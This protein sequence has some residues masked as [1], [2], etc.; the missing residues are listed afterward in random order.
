MF[1]PNNFHSNFFV[2]SEISAKIFPFITNKAKL[3]SQ[4][5]YADILTSIGC[6]RNAFKFGNSLVFFRPKNEQ[7]VH[8]FH[9]LSSEMSQ[10]IGKDISKQF[11]YRQRRAI[12]NSI[13][14]IGSS[15]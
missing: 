14:F 15:K 4:E 10:N 3:Y 6:K 5:V 9:S 2:N 1:K 13:R 8:I 7:F 12:W 11:K